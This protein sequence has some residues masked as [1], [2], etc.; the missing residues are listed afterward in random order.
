[1]SKSWPNLREGE[2][3]HVLTHQS[4]AQNQRIV[5]LANQSQRTPDLS[6]SSKQVPGQAHPRPHDH[7]DLP[8]LQSYAKIGML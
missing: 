3:L 4:M 7:A 8:S 2:Q 6:R 1:M 5:N